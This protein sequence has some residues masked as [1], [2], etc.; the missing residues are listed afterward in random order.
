M[1]DFISDGMTRVA[2]VAAIA[3]PSA[4]TTTELNLGVLMQSFITGDGLVGFEVATSGVDNTGLN[5]LFDTTIPGR[6]S[7][8]NP[9]F[10]IKKQLGTD[11]LFATLIYNAVGFI[12]IRRD[13]NETSAW[14]ST[15]PLEVYPSAFGERRRLTPAL[16]GLTKWE[17][18]VF[19]TSSPSLSAAIA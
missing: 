12:V 15:Q 5:S 10:T 6:K 16:G 7:Y 3:N 2:Y 14:A 8:S 19:F 4:P 13:I 18:D 1:A 11:T 17:T 9:K